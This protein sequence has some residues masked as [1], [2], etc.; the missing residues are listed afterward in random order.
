MNRRDYSGAGNPAYKHGKTRTKLYRIWCGIINRC[1]NQKS[2]SYKWYGNRGI[3]V[4]D[5]WH[6]FSNFYKDMGDYPDGMQIDRIDNDGHY[7]PG[8]CRWVTPKENNPHNRN[9]KPDDMP[10]KNF[11][12]WTVI[13]RDRSKTRRPYYKCRCECSNE[14]IICKSRLVGGYSKQCTSCQHIA[15][16][17][18][19]VRNKDSS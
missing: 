9:P 1:N 11:G 16:R 14:R 12:K 4:H 17:G 19:N 2:G 13:E 18:Y 3:K 7:E 6:D 10:G 15:H 5:S 8:N